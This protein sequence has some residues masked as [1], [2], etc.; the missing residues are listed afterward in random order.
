M[1]KSKTTLKING[2][3]CEHCV[4]T[5]TKSLEGLDGVKKAKVKLK[6]GIAKVAY[7]SDKIGVDGLI[8]AVVEAGYE[9]KA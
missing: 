8:A 3:T 6:S 2:M 5:V 1:A 9:A 4:Q 7:D